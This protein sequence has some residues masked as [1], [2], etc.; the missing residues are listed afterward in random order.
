MESNQG[1]VE[2]L[3]KISYKFL[4]RANLWNEPEWV[5]VEIKFATETD[6]VER[7]NVH[8]YLSDN[9]EKKLKL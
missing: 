5:Q 8:V 6:K 3:N 7:A 9:H 2:L 1:N 4:F